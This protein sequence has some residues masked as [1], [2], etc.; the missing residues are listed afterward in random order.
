VPEVRKG[1]YIPFVCDR[2]EMQRGGVSES[3]TGGPPKRDIDIEKRTPAKKPGHREH[4]ILER[5]CRR[6]SLFC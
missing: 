1:E 4:L 3:G 2:E 6:I 5:G